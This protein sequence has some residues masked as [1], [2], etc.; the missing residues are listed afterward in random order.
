MRGN[1][2]TP[3]L[4]A[5]PIQQGQ[6]HAP[7][8]TR[9]ELQAWFGQARNAFPLVPHATQACPCSCPV[10]NHRA[11]RALLP[12]FMPALLTESGWRLLTAPFTP[13]F[14]VTS[15]RM[16]ACPPTSNT[17]KECWPAF[18]MK[19]ISVAFKHLWKGQSYHISKRN[20]SAFRMAEDALGYLVRDALLPVEI[21]GYSHARS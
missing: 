18:H 1:C 14:R 17:A 11:A 8:R 10:R 7:T 3:E 13:A 19:S 16:G 9:K 20:V 5:E 15:G 2:P 12:L 4:G 21:L 6:P